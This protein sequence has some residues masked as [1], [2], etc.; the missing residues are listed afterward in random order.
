MKNLNALL[1]FL[2]LAALTLP[3]LAA[4]LYCGWALLFGGSLY[5]YNDDEFI[6]V[7]I[8]GS[9]FLLVVAKKLMWASQDSEGGG[10]RLRH[11][12]KRLAR[13]EAHLNVTPPPVPKHKRAAH[14]ADSE[15]VQ[16]LHE[17]GSKMQERLEN[18][19]TVLIDKA[20]H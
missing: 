14:D 1:A 11:I 5:R 6:M 16:T 10:E 8:C 3:V 15:L 9:I 17:H 18:L 20:R 19:E 12:E 7:M 4:V 13:I 2:I